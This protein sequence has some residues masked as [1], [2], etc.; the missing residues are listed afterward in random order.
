MMYQ[1]KETFFMVKELPINYKEIIMEASP[2]ITELQLKKQA[3]LQLKNNFV[4]SL[5][6]AFHFD[7]YDLT[8]EILPLED[9]QVFDIF[10]TKENISFRDIKKKYA[11]VLV[12]VNFTEPYRRLVKETERTREVERVYATSY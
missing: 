12:T 1:G 10:R 11:N 5:D 4:K 6:D 7:S 2:L 3:E 9:H 8:I